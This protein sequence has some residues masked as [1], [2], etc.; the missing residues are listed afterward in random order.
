MKTDSIVQ[1]IEKN[2]YQSGAELVKYLISNGFEFPEYHTYD[3]SNNDLTDLIIYHWY[4]VSEDF[5][6][7]AKKSNYCI[8]KYLGVNFFG[9]T[10]RKNLMWDYP[11][12]SK[13]LGF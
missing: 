2:I 12:L 10:E 4:I 7:R 13:D 8:V 1:Y 9:S 5:A 6:E 11:K 3:A